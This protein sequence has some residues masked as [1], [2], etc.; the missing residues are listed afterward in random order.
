MPPSAEFVRRLLLSGALACVLAGSLGLTGC[1]VGTVTIASSDPLAITGSVHGGVQPV[2]GAT[3]QLFAVGTAGNGSVA[4]NLL[5]TP[6]M[7]DSHGAFT[8]TGDYT[9]P[10]AGTQVYLV[11]RGGNPGFSSNVNNPALVLLSALGSCGALSADAGRSVSL[12]EVSTVAA[13]YALAPFMAAYDHIGASGTNAQGI[14]NAFLD[15]GLLADPFTGLAPQLASNLSVETGKLYALAD[16]IAPCVNSDGGTACAPLFAAATAAGGTAP[17]DVLGALLSIVRNPGRNVLAVFSAI[18]S[19]PPY[20]TTLTSPPSDWTMSLSVTGGGLVEPT[21]LALDGSGNVWVANYGGQ[22]AAGL[23][24]FSPQGT[25]LAGSPFGAGLQTEAY[26]LV[27]DKNGDVWVSSA[28]NVNTGSTVGSVAK[29]QGASSSA[30]GTLVGQFYDSTLNWP[31]SLAADPAGSGSILIGNY[32]GGTVT[33][34]DLNGVFL[35]NLGGGRATFP[36]ALTS[37]TAGGAW[38]GDQGDGNIVHMLAN[39]SVQLV[40]CCNGAQSVKLDPQGNVWATNYYPSGRSSTYSFSEVAPNGSVLLNEQTG[41]GLNSPGGGA[42]D[43]GGQFWVA[44]Y[45]GANGAQ[46]GTFSEIAGNGTTVAPGTP[47]SPASGLGLDAAMSSDYTIAP[48][49]SGNLWLAVR[50]GNSLR[51]FFGL[52]TPTATPATPLPQAP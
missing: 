15:A 45:N 7:T 32:V 41:G 30:P 6:V 5:T 40:A 47:L 11:A 31:E 18:T 10:S 24:A 8:F 27:V 42:V 35:K 17:T 19:T 26:G 37:D 16:A 51:M 2:A 21:Q 12:N 13:A 23:V 38:V 34:Y 43:A 49:A 14:A 50:N 25:P 3:V 4:T 9:C 44:N 29:F 22:H 48:D 39:G 52:A 28:E 36:V 20:P 46:Y 33:T 1:G